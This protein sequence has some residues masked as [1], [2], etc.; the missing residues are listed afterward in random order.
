MTDELLI[1]AFD[2]CLSALA[3]GGSLDDCLARYP[4]GQ[5]ELRSLLVT[6]GAA[7]AM[8]ASATIPQR[9]AM[10]SRARFL[11]GGAQLR[12]VSP[13]RSRVGRWPM[14]RAAVALAALA[15]VVAGTYGVVGASTRSLPG[16]VLYGVKRTVE[17][18]QLLLAPN[19]D[20]RARLETE[21]DERRAE[22]V[23]A[24]TLQKRTARVQFSGPVESME[25]PRWSVR[26][27]SVLLSPQTRVEGEPSVGAIVEVSGT[28]QAD[29]TVLASLIAVTSES[30]MATPMP[31][32]GAPAQATPTAPF[33][34]TSTPP[35]TAALP[36]TETPASVNPLPGASPTPTAEQDQEVEFTGVVEFT[37]ETL[38][39][40]AGQEVTI[41]PATEIGGS[42]QVGQMVEVQA[43]RDR[44]GV[45]IAQ[46]IQVKESTSQPET[47]ATPQPAV[48]P[49][50]SATPQPSATHEANGTQEAEDTHKAYGTY[51][52]SETPWPTR[53]P[54]PTP[55]P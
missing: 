7:R 30:P 25:G 36:P 47:S 26:Q 16:D 9:A 55:T 15:L 32:V 18:T 27:I 46:H 52:P 11:A 41:T 12:P 8:G 34:P 1:E 6:A 17:Q 24:V 45:L 28:S 23:Q 19:E 4:S 54:T 14:P 5:D 2:D 51:E 39:H 3:A 42:P 10:S 43:R 37:S 33:A 44:N 53:T 35:P 22:E 49:E 40:I 38:W 21:F 29:G 48:P 20:S 50:L 13:S 31:T